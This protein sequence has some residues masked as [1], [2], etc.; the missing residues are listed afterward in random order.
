MVS[1]SPSLPNDCLFPP[2]FYFSVPLPPQHPCFFFIPFKL[3]SFH[4]EVQMTDNSREQ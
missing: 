3:S 2:Q 1:G 4:S